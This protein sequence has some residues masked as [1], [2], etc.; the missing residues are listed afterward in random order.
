MQRNNELQVRASP[1]GASLSVDHVCRQ[2]N[3]EMTSDI[4]DWDNDGPCGAAL[5]TNIMFLKGGWASG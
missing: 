5:I 4:V 2:N 1:H 3:V